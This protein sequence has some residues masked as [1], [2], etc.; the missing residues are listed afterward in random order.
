MFAITIFLMTI[1]GTLVSVENTIITHYSYGSIQFVSCVCVCALCGCELFFSFPFTLRDSF[2][3][4]CVQSRYHLL[5]F[6]IFCW[7]V[8]PYLHSNS[9]Y[10]FFAF[11][12]YDSTGRFL[13]RFLFPRLSLCVCVCASLSYFGRHFSMSIAAGCL[14][15]S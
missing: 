11:F 7:L 3:L 9:V 2:C 12:V 6:P 14:V 13:R 4:S 15:L 1:D 5:F 10:K 8:T